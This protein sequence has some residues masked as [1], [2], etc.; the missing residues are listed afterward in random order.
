METARRWRAACAIRRLIDSLFC[1][2]KH[3]GMTG[4]KPLTGDD[5]ALLATAL[6]HY[7]A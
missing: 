1:S 6:N 4:S 7:W 2:R 5:T 3:P